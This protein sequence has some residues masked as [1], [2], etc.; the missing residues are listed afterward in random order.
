MFNHINQLT[1]IKLTGQKPETFKTSFH[2]L[3]QAFISERN[4]E[5]IVV[6]QCH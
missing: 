4:A 1:L 3:L 2:L 6:L 5:K